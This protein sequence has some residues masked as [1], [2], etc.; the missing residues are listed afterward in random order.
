MA[1]SGRRDGIGTLATGYRCH[2]TDLDTQGAHFDRKRNG[3]QSVLKSA[4]MFIKYLDNTNFCPPFLQINGFTTRKSCCT[5]A[6]FTELRLEI[7]M[8]FRALQ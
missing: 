7:V 1:E 2:K 3:V 5:E 4:S 8:A 6:W